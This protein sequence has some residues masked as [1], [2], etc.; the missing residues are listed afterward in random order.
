MPVISPPESDRKT[1]PS[2]TEAGSGSSSG[3]GGTVETFQMLQGQIGGDTV[4]LKLA[5]S[6][7]FPSVAVT[8]TLNR[9]AVVSVP[10]TAPVAGS[11]NSPEGSPKAT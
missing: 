1:V 2:S 4:Q 11:M 5:L 7:R 6:V 3:A 9:P 8:V 10:V